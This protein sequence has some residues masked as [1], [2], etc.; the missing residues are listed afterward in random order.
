MA[1]ITA[2]IIPPP[3]P[4]LPPPR[5]KLELDLSFDEALWLKELSG[6]VVGHGPQRTFTTQL[7]GALREKLVEVPRYTGIERNFSGEVRVK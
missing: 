3:T 1:T 6:S 7:F 2:Q 4:P 5:V